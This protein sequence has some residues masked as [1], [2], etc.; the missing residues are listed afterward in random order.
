MQPDHI[1]SDTA[2]L[3]ALYLAE[4]AR[5]EQ[6]EEAA[7]QWQARAQIPELNP[8]PVLRLAADGSLRYANAAATPIV[9]E[10][11]AAGPSRPRMRIRSTA[12]RG[13]RSVASSTR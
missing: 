3:R 13:R 4:R 7:V 6:A 9:A 8:N 5:R 2:A 12:S 1:P 10:L 11:L